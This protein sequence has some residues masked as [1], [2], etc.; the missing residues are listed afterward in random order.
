M[1]GDSE[2]VNAHLAIEAQLELTNHVY[3]K[4]ASISSSKFLNRVL[5]IMKPRQHTK[6]VH[7]QPQA[8]PRH[9]PQRII[10]GSDYEGMVEWGRGL[11]RKSLSSN[12]A[13]IC[14][15]RRPS[16]SFCLPHVNALAPE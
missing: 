8:L 3:A 1:D 15:Y 16:I 9:C 7:R 2:I 6:G 11:T 10:G 14:H 13:G 5:L 12:D 4:G